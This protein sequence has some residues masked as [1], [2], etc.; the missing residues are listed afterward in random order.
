MHIW[1]YHGLKVYY[2]PKLDGM[3]TVL[4]GPI[5]KF[6]K[7]SFHS[8]ESPRLFEWCSGPGFIGFALLAEGMCQKLCLADINPLAVECVKKTIIENNL[9]DSVSYYVSDNFKTI[10]EGE[11][12][13]MVVANPPNYFA[14]NPKH[15][16]WNE[17]KDDLRPN[18]P[19]W[20][21]HR[22]F[23]NNVSRYLNPEALLLISEVEPFKKEVF[24][25]IS[26]PVP[27]DIRQNLP[28]DDFKKMVTDGGLICVDTKH[29]FTSAG[30]QYWMMI[31]KKGKR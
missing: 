20:K 4:A 16:A 17:F 22:E 12:F 18:D 2:Y 9:Q 28:I 1:N 26:H 15:Y 10:P 23:Y 29:Y 19:G 11:R 31:S 7:K 5:V 30:T 25:P 13:N 27:Y 24:I 21:I 6:I 8:Y 14:I 3:G